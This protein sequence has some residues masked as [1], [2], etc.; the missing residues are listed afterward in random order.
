MDNEKMGTFISEL[1][2]SYQM[3]QKG[4]AAKLN[5][6][7]KAVSKWERGLSCP[8][9]SLL[10]PL[11]DI[12]G[13]TVGELLNGERND[14]SPASVEESV[15]N[16]LQYAAKAVKINTE[17]ILNISAAIF[18]GLLLLGILA[19][20]I[21]DIAIAGTFTW[22]LIPISSSVFAWLLFFPIFKF[23][24]KGIIFSL[25]IF[26]VLVI[27]FLFILNNL[28]DSGGFLIPIG[29]RVS[30]V[31]SAYLWIVFVIFKILRK[32]M[33]MASAF[34]LLLG[35]PLSLLI[36]FILSNFI[37]AT[38]FDVWD[39]MSF[40][41]VIILTVFLFTMDYFLQKRKRTKS[42]EIGRG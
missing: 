13:I 16:A 31:G 26:S 22:S 19:C 3:T 11:S 7:D 24:L 32:R 39:A 10:A 25:I 23:R 18:S 42:R 12:L 35:I 4:L 14:D 40:S 29:I 27:P 41:I 6:S 2:K 37:N 33:L 28:V 30:I 20:T 15:D 5:V 9:I 34:S 36:N 17:T 21:V 8:D 38:I 1:R